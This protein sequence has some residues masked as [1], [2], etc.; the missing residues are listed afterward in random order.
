MQGKLVDLLGA[1]LVHGL[2]PDPSAWLGQEEMKGAAGTLALRAGLLV[3]SGFL[4]GSSASILLVLRSAAGA[5]P[6]PSTGAF[7]L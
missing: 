6:S 1:H 7:R 5:G 3:K 4:A 2:H